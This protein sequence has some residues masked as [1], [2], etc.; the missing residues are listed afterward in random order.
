MSWAFTRP[1]IYRVTF[2]A[3]LHA[4]DGTTHALRPATVV[5]AV[6]V[7][8]G[9][10]AAAEGRTVLDAGHADVTVDLTTGGGPR[11]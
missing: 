7:S 1:G 8:G 9:A 11:R 3:R 5:L 2:A 10:V 6:G 4:A